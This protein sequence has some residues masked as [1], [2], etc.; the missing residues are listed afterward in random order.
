[1]ACLSAPVY[2]NPHA[3]RG[4]GGGGCG[5]RGEGVDK[6]QLT[7]AQM[8]GVAC[9]NGFQNVNHVLSKPASGRFIGGAQRH[10]QR[11]QGFLFYVHMGHDP[12][13]A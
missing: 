2:A 3:H 4:G 1:M 8:S 11:R 6:A 12:L 9:N 5:G 10:V 13:R 7:G